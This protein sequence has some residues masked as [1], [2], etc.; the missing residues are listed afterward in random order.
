MTSVLTGNLPAPLTELVGRARELS[1]VAEAIERAR[2]VTIVGPGG[3]GK[4]RLALAAAGR[5]ATDFEETWWVELGGVAGEGLVAS[6]ILATCEVTEAPGEEPLAVVARHFG[7]RRA[8][9]VLDNCEHVAEE[10][11]T[12][13][14]RALVGAAGLRV[15]ATSRE[16]LAVGGERVLR[17][18]GLD[19]RHEGEAF[20]LFLERAE[21]MGFVPA[22]GEHEMIAH[23][24]ERLDGLPLA[25]E[26]A[27]A[28][29]GILSVAEIARRLDDADVL[30]RQTSR[31]APPRHRT[32][33]DALAWSHELLPPREQLLFAI[34]SVFRGSFSLLAAESVSS[35]AGIERR[36]VLP[37][38]GA[39]VDKSLVQVADRGAE[40]RYRLLNTIHTYAA[41]RLD[42]LAE[43]DAVRA[44]HAEFFLSL[45]AQAR[46]GLEGPEQARWLERLE[47]EHENMRTVLR[48]H[49]A[50]RPDVAG[51]LAALLWPF[52]YRRGYYHE[53]RSWLEQAAAATDGMEPQVA[54]DVLA[55]AGAAAFLQ[56]DYGP[57]G[58]QLARARELYEAGGDKMG[59][60]G[61]LQRLGS[62]A[63]EQGR[64]EEAIAMHT[65]AGELWRELGD[66][67]GIAASEDMLAFVAW[68]QNDGETARRHADVA[69][70]HFETNGLR[71]ET[72]GALVNR[73]MASVCLGQ[74]DGAEA[75]LRRAL[76]IAREISF[77]EGIAWA[78][79]E[80]GALTHGEDT[81]SGAL[82]A[83]SL[84]THVALGDRWRTASLLE[85]IA[86]LLL[87]EREPAQAVQT[88]AA[89]SALRELLAAPVPPVERPALEAAMEGLRERLG[90]AEFTRAWAR[91]LGTRVERAVELALAGAPGADD[92]AP[93][94]S[95]DGLAAY[96]LTER[97]V[98]VLRLLSG[99]LT[100]REIGAELYISPGTAAIHVSNI[101]RKLRVASRVQA[102]GIA[103]Q[104]GLA[105][106]AGGD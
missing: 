76:A 54:A 57:G 90:E 30:L 42:A 55:S 70:E 88:I 5:A 21:A 98:A 6:T 19:A 29:T 50:S 49:R 2:L 64:Y 32:L 26:L 33:D 11:A 89:A 73:A 84:R 71:Q 43:R 79:N 96:E 10:C 44:A 66:P 63:R 94:A 24:C 8:L 95:A 4:T 7:D 105:A 56:C 91:G 59:V 93:Q 99:G 36:D 15:L 51:R 85:T 101:L 60:A 23:V 61:V 25:V 34:L 106:T 22:E 39:L 77:L 27:A 92:D 17:L 72:A 75:L 100:N 9:L 82:L 81:Q 20:Q 3:V 31:T 48:E 40:H 68:L 86:V 13:A 104:L 37:L 80:L 1:A 87:A 102:A 46:D 65:A 35:A 78:A 16:P 74:R 45:A 67:G 103:H 69:L 12:F 38:L 83:E 97:E 58:E 14:Q 62:I 41:T 52:W 47:L 28:R 53:A 18:A